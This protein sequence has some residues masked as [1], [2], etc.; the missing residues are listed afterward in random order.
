M[1]IFGDLRVL[2]MKSHGAALPGLGLGAEG[3]VSPEAQLAACSR[4]HGIAHLHFI[5]TLALGSTFLN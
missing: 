3:H 2:Y 5:P 1:P 4:P